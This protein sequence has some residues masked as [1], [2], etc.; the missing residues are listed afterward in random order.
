M[1]NPVFFQLFIHMAEAPALQ[2]AFKACFPQA[3][4]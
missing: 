3:S 1:A 2:C 4:Q